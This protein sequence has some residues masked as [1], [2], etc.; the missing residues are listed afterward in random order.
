MPKD[1]GSGLEKLCAA[2]RQA[3]GERPGLAICTNVRHARKGAR[4]SRTK[5]A[6]EE[7]A[8]YRTTTQ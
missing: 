8:W 6:R 4:L 1:I 2:R 3:C 5:I 7:N